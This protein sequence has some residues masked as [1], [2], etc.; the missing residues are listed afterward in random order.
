MLN[1][2]LKHVGVL[3]A[4]GKMGSGIAILLLQEMAYLEAETTEEVGNG[5]F[6][7][8]LI[9]A[10]EA[11]LQNFAKEM[12]SYL[13]KY[14][15][16]HINALRSFFASNAALISNF[17]IIQYFVDGAMRRVRFDTDPQAAKNSLL[18]FEAI[19]EDVE[20][21][22]DVFSRLAKNISSD[23]LFLTNTSSIPIHLLNEKAR[24]NNRIIGF[25]FYN[26]PLV[27]KL[28]ELI[29]PAHTHSRAVSI[30]AMAIS[31]EKLYTLVK[32]FGNSL[33][34]IPFRKPFI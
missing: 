21:K 16:R 32:K 33:E 2:V 10:N 30:S 25:H 19:V 26:P 23:A 20:T 8:V 18:I 6:R 12:K 3:G 4:G 13:I 5:D 9:D 31:L 28:V 1:E 17:D 34:C 27:Q 24:L 11:A 15:E 7:L 22:V 14:A 29:I